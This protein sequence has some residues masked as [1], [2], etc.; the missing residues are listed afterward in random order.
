MFLGTPQ[1]LRTPVN[2]NFF[3][4]LLVSCV[5]KFLPHSIY[6]IAHLMSDAHLIASGAFCKVSGS[7]LIVSSAHL[8]LLG[9]Q[10]SI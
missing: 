8:I 1:I 4:V 9:A 2:S 5:H 6:H 3:V 7:H 10:H